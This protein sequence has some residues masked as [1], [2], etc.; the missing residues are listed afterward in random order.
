MKNMENKV[1]NQSCE[2]NWFDKN[3][4]G[5]LSKSGK[6]DEKPSNFFH[7]QKITGLRKSIFDAPQS[8]VSFDEDFDEEDFY[9]L[10]NNPFPTEFERVADMHK[11]FIELKKN[12]KDTLQLQKEEEKLF[13]RWAKTLFLTYNALP[14]IIEIV[15]NLVES[16]ALAQNYSSGLNYCAESTY[17]QVLK[18]VNLV[19]RKKSLISVFNLTTDLINALDREDQKLVQ[20]RYIKRMSIPK[21]ASAFGYQ[22]RSVFRLYDRMFSHANKAFKKLRLFPERILERVKGEPWLLQWF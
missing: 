6:N 11:L 12:K 3:Y 19:E 5:F 7:N 9:P 10:K 2:K 1:E 17:E 8:L 22:E 21:I 20:L 15:D 16:R 14:N 4:G 13:K 18:V